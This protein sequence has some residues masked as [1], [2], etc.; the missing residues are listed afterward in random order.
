MLSQVIALLLV[1]SVLVACGGRSGLLVDA[2]LVTAPENPDSDIVDFDAANAKEDDASAGGNAED[3]G[4]VNFDTADAE[5]GTGC[6]SITSLWECLHSDLNCSDCA[7]VGPRYDG[8]PPVQ[9]FAC[10]ESTAP[11]PPALCR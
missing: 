1:L 2:P 6:S 8:G 5:K 11:L 3:S 7:S 9:Q 4:V 10:Y